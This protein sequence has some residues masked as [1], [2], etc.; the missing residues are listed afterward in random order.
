WLEPFWDDWY[1]CDDTPLVVNVSPGFA[2]TGAG[3]PQL[4]R[5][6]GLL[7]AAVEVRE[8][9]AAEEL[10]PDLD[11]GAPRCMREY[12]RLFS[13]TRIPGASRDT[14]ARFPDSRHVVVIH[15]EHFFALDVLDPRGHPYGSAELE[16]ALARIIAHVHAGQ[17]SLGVLTTDNRRSWA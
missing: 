10:E 9:I 5:A 15:G 12:G 14:L 2:L 3:R 8:L 4:E 7:A 17:P 11:S 16:G 6:A 1:L 13:A